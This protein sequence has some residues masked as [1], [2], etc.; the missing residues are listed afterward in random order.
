VHLDTILCN[1]QGLEDVLSVNELHSTTHTTN[2][3]QSRHSWSWHAAKKMNAEL[4]IALHLF[5][6]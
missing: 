1:S 2:V 3:A 4:T 5:Y 6:N